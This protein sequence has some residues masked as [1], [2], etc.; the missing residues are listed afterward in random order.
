MFKSI[1]SHLLR[2]K[3]AKLHKLL[4]TR[5]DLIDTARPYIYPRASIKLSSAAEI[6]VRLAIAQRVGAKAGICIF[7][8]YAQECLKL[9]INT[10]GL[11]SVRRATCVSNARLWVLFYW[12]LRSSSGYLRY[13]LE[14]FVAFNTYINNKTSSQP[15]S[16]TWATRWGADFICAALRGSIWCELRASRRWPL[17]FDDPSDT[18]L[19]RHPLRSRTF[20][21]LRWAIDT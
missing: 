15:R 10:T 1:I 5:H 19:S 13:K 8:I 2:Q 11:S 6:V 9:E 20:L 4:C 12:I 16:G 17:E 3:V 7:L 14:G 18:N 21:I